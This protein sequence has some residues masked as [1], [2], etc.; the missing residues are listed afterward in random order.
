MG[1]L[2]ERR[3]NMRVHFQDAYLR[4]GGEWDRLRIVSKGR[5]RCND[6]EAACSVKLWQKVLLGGGG[7]YS[8]AAYVGM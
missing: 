1:R 5:W 2:R 3:D 4:V 8:T 7:S 6:V